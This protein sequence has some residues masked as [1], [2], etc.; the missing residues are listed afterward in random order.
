MNMGGSGVR[1]SESDLT[2]L[3]EEAQERLD[4]SRLDADVNAFLQHELI[5]LNSRN[6][7]KV[8]QRLGEVE[9]ALEGTLRE[10]DRVLFGGSVAKH[11]YVDGVSDIDSIIVLDA[12]SA[13]EDT[14]EQVQHKVE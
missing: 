3:R 1:Y 12:K 4:R 13:G 11:T 2:K 7:E 6:T 14:P 8:N 5:D 10:F 9:E